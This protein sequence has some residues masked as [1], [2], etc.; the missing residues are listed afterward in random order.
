MSGGEGRLGFSGSSSGDYETGVLSGIK[1]GR[2]GKG[3]VGFF[4]GGVGGVKSK[5]CLPSLDV[6]V[7][8]EGF[9]SGLLPGEF[10]ALEG[11][12]GEVKSTF[13]STEVRKRREDSSIG[14]HY[15]S[16]GGVGD[17][18][19]LGGSSGG[20]DSGCTGSVGLGE[21]GFSGSGLGGGSFGEGGLARI[22]DSTRGAITT[23]R[24]PP[25]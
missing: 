9:G 25:R 13:G 22:E 14:R 7:G 10:G 24:S 4:G 18:S 12:I 16:F 23:T 20:S 5:P 3:R 19:S 8:F 17:G 1:R 11:D 21:C 2:L 15:G 6:V